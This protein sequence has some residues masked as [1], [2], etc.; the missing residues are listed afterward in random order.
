MTVTIKCNPEELHIPAIIFRNEDHTIVFIN[1]DASALYGFSTD[2]FLHLNVTQLYFN[3]D[4]SQVIEDILYP[5]TQSQHRKG[6]LHRTKSGNVIAVQIIGMPIEFNDEDC[7]MLIIDPMDSNINGNGPVPSS[8]QMQI[9][10]ESQ[11]KVKIETLFTDYRFLLNSSPD[12]IFRIRR[13]G[14][15]LEVFPENSPRLAVPSE[16]VIGRNIREILPTHIAEIAMKSIKD[17]FERNTESRC[18]YSLELPSGRHYFESRNKPVNS[19]EAFSIIRDI[20]EMKRTQEEMTIFQNR[21]QLAQEMALLG[22]WDYNHA[23]GV[24]TLSDFLKSA[25]NL[26]RDCETL[27]LQHFIGLSLPEFVGKLEDAFQDHFTNHAPLRMEFKLH[28]AKGKEKW[29]YISAITRFDDAGKPTMTT[30][31]LQD[32]STRIDMKFQLENQGS[33]FSSLLDSIPDLLFIKNR[34]GKYL[35]VNAKF[36]ELVA[37]DVSKIIGNSDFELFEQ[38]EAKQYVENDRK[39]LES[40][41]SLIIQEIV[42]NALGEN[43][44]FESLKAPIFGNNDEIMGTIGFSRNINSRIELENK[45]REQTEALTA[46]TENVPGILVQAKYI[47]GAGLSILYVSKGFRYLFPVDED[48]IYNNVEKVLQFIVPDDRFRLLQAVQD[49]S[50]FMQNLIMDIRVQDEGQNIRYVN[51]NAK[52]SLVETG[53]YLW[54]GYLTDITDQKRMAEELQEKDFMLNNLLNT[55]EDVVYI[56]DAKTLQ[57]VSVSP[58]AEKVYGIPLQH[59]YDDPL[60][61]QKMVHPD[62]KSLIQKAIFELDKTVKIDCQYRVIS[63]DGSVKWL[64]DKVWLSEGLPGRGKLIQGIVVDITKIKNLESEIQYHAELLQVLLDLANGFINIPVKYVDQAINFAIEKVGLFVGTDRSYIFSYDFR[65]NDCSNTYEWCAEGISPEIDNLQNVPLDAIPHWVDSHM[66]NKPMIVED[67]FALSPEDGIRQILEPQGVKSLITLPVFDR[68]ALVGFIGFDSVK[69]YKLYTEREIQLL[70]FLSEIFIN[71]QNRKIFENNLIES[72]KRFQS[73]YNNASLGLYRI[74]MKGTILMV[75]PALAEI[76]GYDNPG[77]LEGRHVAEMNIVDQSVLAVIQ[78][79]LSKNDLLAGYEGF[80]RNKNGEPIYIRESVRVTRDENGNPAYYDGAAEDITL[81]KKA[82]NALVESEAKFR[83]LA[84]NISD[85]I[86]LRDLINDEVIYYNPS[87]ARFFGRPQE[88]E[89]CR[90]TCFLDQCKEEDRDR[91]SEYLTCEVTHEKH[92]DFVLLDV[93]NDPKWFRIDVYPVKD[94]TG[95]VVRQ[96]GIATDITSMI[97][98]QE[99]L[100]RSLEMEKKVGELKTRFVSMASHEFKTPLA[101]IMMASETIQNFRSRFTDQDYDKYLERIKRN[102]THLSSM[103]NNVLNLSKME[104]GN[105]QI[106]PE[107][108]AINEF[109]GKWFSGYQSNHPINHDIILE[110]TENELYINVDRHH[111]VHV[112]DNLFSNGM[113]YSPTNSKIEIRTRAQSGNLTISVRD[114]GIGIPEKDRSTMFSPFFRASNSASVHGT[115]LGLSLI[116]Q[117]VEQNGGRIW[118]ESVEGEGTIFYV[119]FP[120]ADSE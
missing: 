79:K 63:P 56:A 104:S 10:M 93:N 23:E 91:L 66:K 103:I 95:E 44:V 51:I 85:M 42:K 119:E 55:M 17:C 9:S 114:H 120:T 53:Q 39:V 8:S 117:M 61:F 3:P 115:G 45:L 96:V 26:E 69:H 87:L 89:N 83:Q 28:T 5:A 47:T 105:M 90:I 116:K 77:E 20:T 36:K 88:S 80:W 19:Q 102:T 111:L 70:Q 30:G 18:E 52:P 60:V 109:I 43:L 76:L 100:R 106:T 86:W 22:Y 92:G 73:I 35:I 54:H 16:Q 72:R 71:A 81:R 21:L 46:V 118:F 6:N 107:R 58:S 68:G 110:L 94:I 14:T 11:D 40:G 108:I 27:I 50:S 62:D 34:E 48:E 74:D 64:L 15:Y 13:D 57:V 67:V 29:F 25:L 41:Q 78:Q 98:A 4:Q 7:T 1:A 75:N 37:L 65:N 49:H 24:I 101:S 32:I 82:E 112:M 84:E 31:I 59:F 99:A 38:D 2:E 113:K 33:L 12:L 97:E